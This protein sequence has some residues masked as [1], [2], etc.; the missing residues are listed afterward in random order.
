MGREVGRHFVHEEQQF[1]FPI[2]WLLGEHPIVEF[3]REFLNEILLLVLVL[4]GVQVDDVERNFARD[5]RL[6]KRI[7]VDGYAV[8]EEQL[9]HA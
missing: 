1:E 4:D 9:V 3:P 5:G 7:D 8:G 2:G 6:N